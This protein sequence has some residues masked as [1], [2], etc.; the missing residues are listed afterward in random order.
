[1][2]KE[3]LPTTVARPAQA[4]VQ[5]NVPKSSFV[6]SEAIEAGRS[7]S[8][9]I[10]TVGNIVGDEVARRA[11][12]K[13]EEETIKVTEAFNVYALKTKERAIAQKA[14]YKIDD[15]IPIDQAWNTYSE[16]VSS[17]VTKGFNENQMRAFNEAK[18]KHGFITHDNFLN[19]R[20]QNAQRI[21][22]QNLAVRAKFVNQD[23]IDKN[24]NMSMKI[25]IDTN[26]SVA[27][28]KMTTAS[29]VEYG[30][31]A[32]YKLPDD[33]TPEQLPALIKVAEKE[34]KEAL[35]AGVSNKVLAQKE[36]VVKAL[37]LAQTYATVKQKTIDTA[38]VGIF[39]NFIKAGDLASADAVVSNSDPNIPVEGFKVSDGVL[40]QMD[41]ILT[42][43]KEIAKVS[44]AVNDTMNR[45]M[46]GFD[47]RKNNA[48]ELD[49]KIIKIK[50]NELSKIK[51]TKLHSK[52][53]TV[54]DKQLI[55][56]KKIIISAQ[57][58]DYTAKVAQMQKMT[59][60]E[61]ANFL[62]KLSIDYS[63]FQMS[64]FTK[65]EQGIS[66]IGSTTTEAS[67]DQNGIEHDVIQAARD[68]G[69]SQNG[70]WR[71][72]KSFDDVKD[73]FIEKGGVASQNA[74]RRLKKNYDEKDLVIANSVL[75]NVLASYG[76]K[77]TSQKQ[78][79][80]RGGAKAV[81]DM[82]PA[83]KLATPEQ[84]Q[85]AV[86]KWLAQKVTTESW[87]FNL[88]TDPESRSVN[89]G[90]E[91]LFTN[92]QAKQ[93]YNASY[94]E[95]SKSGELPVWMAENPSPAKVQRFMQEEFNYI[96]GTDSFTGYYRLANIN[97]FK[98]IKGFK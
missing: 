95:R 59:G 63:P 62:E 50:R 6:P 43:R 78:F 41:T 34:R 66:G 7:I 12:I 57:S 96:P 4:Q 32:G 75:V 3:I 29:L 81:A 87:W 49:A 77:G 16:S 51:N 58:A 39:N 23:A 48:S 89:L 22:Q 5:V 86:G 60:S 56:T 73:L 84:V 36:G 90:R 54:L 2:A 91:Q 82:L 93:A 30:K 76:I 24:N 80:D 97:P 31:S 33:Y 37:K 28:T 35:N 68:R 74:V 38:K 52:Y 14:N 17:E 44:V 65:A 92:V 83:G 70:K 46:G 98:Y 26:T 25:A 55:E 42:N 88:D 61:R 40:V 19:F 18:A 11:K 53:N 64:K 10:G 13:A 20:A 45:A 85:V 9:F 67:F 8:R 27:G 69:I 47:F 94:Q 21:K 79:I 15:E 1:M 71:E 72:V